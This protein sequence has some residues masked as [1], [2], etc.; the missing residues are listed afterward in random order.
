MACLHAPGDR[1]HTHALDAAAAMEAAEKQGSVPALGASSAA[2]S[3]SGQPRCTQGPH[4]S[5]GHCFT[6]AV[7]QAAHSHHS[8]VSRKRLLTDLKNYPMYLHL[9]LRY[10]GR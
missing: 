7:D 3:A 4:T 1:Q 2:S 8:E 10:R 6:H 9:S 5:A